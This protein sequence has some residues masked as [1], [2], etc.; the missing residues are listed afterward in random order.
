MTDDTAARP[1][2]SRDLLA[3]ELLD[4]LDETFET[5]HGIYLDGGT[6][7]FGTLDGV[8]AAQASRASSRSAGTIAAKVAH[9]ILYLEVLER[10]IATGDGEKVDWGEVWR[11]VAAVDTDGWDRLRESLR[12]TFERVRALVA[13]R[14][15]WDDEATIAG[16]LGITVHTAYHLGEMREALGVLRA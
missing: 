13:D 12:S 3:H 7:L 11:T 1:T 8:T 16:A 6:S 10:Y 5:H 15:D 2:V 9:V 14:E 4:I